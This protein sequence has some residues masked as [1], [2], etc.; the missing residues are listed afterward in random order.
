MSCGPIA[1]SSSSNTHHAARVQHLDPMRVRHAS[2]GAH[3]HDGFDAAGAR[4]STTWWRGRPL[5][6]AKNAHKTNTKEQFD[7]AMKNGS[8]FFEGDVRKEIHGDR[9]EMRH[10]DGQ[11]TGDNLTLKEWLAK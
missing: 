6:E 1:P 4:P 3:V 7:E 2:H 9:I 10:D 11:E 5:S 8:N